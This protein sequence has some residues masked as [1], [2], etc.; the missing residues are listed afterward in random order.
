M[1]AFI[2]NTNVMAKAMTAILLNFNTFGGEG[3][4]RTA[5]LAA[6]TDAKKRPARRSAESSF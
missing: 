2:V 1:S 3:T 6:P 4:C 5:L